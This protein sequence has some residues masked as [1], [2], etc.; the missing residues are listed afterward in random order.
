MN[1]HRPGDSN[2]APVAT[3]SGRHTIDPETIIIQ[4]R[5]R[6]QAKLFH[7]RQPNDAKRYYPVVN[8]NS[9]CVHHQPKN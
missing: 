9:G 2:P 1:E 4:W 7:N 6:S 8:N 5:A 3:V